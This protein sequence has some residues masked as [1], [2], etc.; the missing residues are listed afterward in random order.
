MGDSI[1]M[2]VKEIAYKGRE[3]SNGSGSCKHRNELSV[4]IKILVQEFPL[5]ALQCL[6]S[7]KA[8]VLLIQ[9]PSLEARSRTHTQ[10]IVH[11]KYTKYNEEK[12]Q[13]PA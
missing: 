13:C 1:K 2:N 9:A 6:A 3:Y 7:S 12:K 8:L 4:F 5:T 11:M 10:H